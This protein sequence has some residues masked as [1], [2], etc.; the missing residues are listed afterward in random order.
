MRRWRREYFLLHEGLLW[1]VIFMA[2][3]SVA[4][5]FVRSA[6]AAMRPAHGAIISLPDPSVDRASG[7][8]NY[9]NSEADTLYHPVAVAVASDGR[10]FVLESDG[11]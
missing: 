11:A 7:Q 2:V 8:I 5:L 6:P 10:L 4:I 3:L 1:L 9:S